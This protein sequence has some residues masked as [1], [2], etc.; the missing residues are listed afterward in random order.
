MHWYGILTRGLISSAKI[1]KLCVCDNPPYMKPSFVSTTI[2]YWEQQN[3]S[4]NKHC[5]YQI[6]C[7]Y[8]IAFLKIQREHYYERS[9]DQ[10]FFL[11]KNKNT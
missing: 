5:T 1:E 2:R 11:N 4:T 10:I 8:G 6:Y 7:E 9:L 3:H